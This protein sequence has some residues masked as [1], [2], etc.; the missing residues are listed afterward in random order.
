MLAV[1]LAILLALPNTAVG[2]LIGAGTVEAYADGTKNVN[3][4]SV[5]SEYYLKDATTTVTFTPK[6]GFYVY[7]STDS[8]APGEVTDGE[9]VDGN[10]WKTSTELS[11]SGGDGDAV[12]VYYW[13]TKVKMMKEP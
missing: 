10:T 5:E 9:N 8:T 3:L 2:R 6:D 1:M 7:A 13:Q 4:A 12:T 11:V